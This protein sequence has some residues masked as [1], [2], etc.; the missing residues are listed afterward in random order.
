MLYSKYFIRISLF[1]V[2]VFACCC[3]Q[4]QL[5]TYPL[6]SGS[7]TPTNPGVGNAYPSSTG[8][9]SANVTTGVVS[10]G[11]NLEGA[12]A[13]SYNST[14]LRVKLGSGFN[15]WPGSPTDDYHVDVPIAP[16][17]NYD[18][19]ITGVSFVVSVAN[20]SEPLSVQILYRAGTGP[21]HNLGTAQSC[22]SVATV[23]F[24]TLNEGFYN[25]NNYTFRFYFFGAG[26]TKNQHIR[27]NNLVFNGTT[28]TPPSVKPTAHTDVASPF[29]T[30]AF[31]V[32]GHF[33]QGAGFHVANKAGFITSTNATPTFAN[34]TVTYAASPTSPLSENVNFLTPQTTYYT[35]AFVITS[36][37]T[38]LAPEI[39]PVTTFPYS[40]PLLNTTAPSNVLSNKATSG[41]NLIDSGGYGVVEK[42]VVY[43]ISNNLDYYTDPHTSNG[44]GNADYWSLM[45]SLQ[46]STKYYVMA[47]ARNQIGVGYGGLD[48]FTTLPAVPVISAIPGNLDFG[49]VV[50]STTAPIL[51]YKLSGA[52]LTGGSGVI[53]LTA[54]GGYKICATYNGSYGTTLSVPYSGTTLPNKIIYVQS[55]NT[56][57][58]N[59]SG[60]ITHSGGGA[61][62]PN[63]DTVFLK[64]AIVQNPDTLSN[65]GSDFWTGFGYQ[66]KMKDNTT[67]FDT[68]LSGKGSHLSL[69]VAAGSQ[70][71]SVIVELPGMTAPTFPRKVYVPANGFVEI[72][73]F[74]VGDGNAANPT[75]GP[76]TRLYYTGVSKRGIHIYSKNGT[77][78][79]CWMY[80]WNTGDAAAGAMLFPT[81]TWN[82]S[83]VVQSV[84]GKANNS[85]YNNNSFFFVIAKED[86]TVVTFKPT[87]DILDSN[88]Q[89]IFT[90][91]HLHNPTYVKYQKDSTYKVTLNKGEVFNAMG[92]VGDPAPASADPGALDLSG[93]VVST[94]CD[95]K[96][97]VFGGNGRCVIGTAGSSPTVGNANCNNPSSGSDNLIQQMF[98]KVAWGTTY[99]TVP[100][101]NMADNLFRVYVQ[102]INTD[103]KLN[104]V[105]LPKINLIKGLY[106]QFDL[107]SPAKVES[108]IPVSVTQFIVSGACQHAASGNIGKGDPEMITLSPVQ[109][110]IKST[111]VYSATFKNGNTPPS[112][113]CSYI[114]VVVKGSDGVSN[115]KLD[116]LTAGIDTGGN[117]FTGAIYAPAS[118]T[119]TNVNAF[120]KHPYDT[121]YYYAT[122]RVSSKAKHT[123]FSTQG[124][125]A[126]AYGV[127]DGES[128]GYN[129]G[130]TINNLSAIKFALNP[131]G[132]DTSTGSIKTCKNN[133]VTLQIALPYDT[134]TVNSIVWDAGS[135]GILYSPT[136]PNNSTLNPNTSKPAVTGIIVKDGRTFYIYRSPVQYQ[137]FEEG[138][139]KVKVTVNGTFVSDCG[140]VEYQNIS[141]I[142]G[143]DDISFTAVPAGCGSKS[144]TISDASTPLA[145][146]T[147]LKW[148]WD[149][150]DISTVD[151][152]RVGIGNAP[153][154]SVNPH[155]YPANNAYTI[156]LTTINSVGCFSV[157]SV[158]INL[159]FGI[160]TSFTIAKDT[161]CPGTAGAF[162]PTSST[163]AAKWFWDFGDGSPVDSSNATAA[164]V[165]HNYVQGDTFYVV[166]H[167][168]KTVAGCPSAIMKDTIY[169]TH[170]PIADFVLP[171]GVCLPGTTS[172]TNN[173]DT[174][175]GL[176]SNSMPYI[177]HWDFGVPSPVNDDT[178]NVKNPSYSYPNVTPPA[179]GYP[180]SLIATSKFG[181]V[182]TATIKNLNNIYPKPTAAISNT[183]DK[184]V[185]AGI[186]AKFFD[187]SPGGSGQTVNSWN[188]IFKNGTS[189]ATNP[190]NTYTTNILDTVKLFIGTDKGCQSD[191]ATWVI[192]VNPKP[193]AGTILPSSCLTSSSLNFKDNS[194]VAADDSVQ[195]P[196]TYTWTFGDGTGTFTTKDS[197]HTYATTGT[198]YI[199]HSITTLNGC[200]DTKTDTFELAG[201]KP[202]AYFTIPHRNLKYCDNEPVYLL[203]SSTISIGTI[204]KV[205]IRWDLN[206]NYSNVVTD[207]TPS[208]G[209]GGSTKQYS[210]NYPKQP[211]SQTYTVALYAYSSS[212]CYDS[213]TL[214]VDVF[215]APK[216]LFDTL[217]GVCVSSAPIRIDKALDSSGKFNSS[218]FANHYYT[219]NGVSSDSL[220]DP[221][222][223]GVG[224]HY[225]KALFTSK[226]PFPRY[227]R[228]SAIAPITV[229]ASPT[230]S[231]DTALI[232]CEK[233][234]MAF[235]DKSIAG[236]GTGNISKWLWKFGDP[237]KSP[238]DTSTSNPATYTY[239]NYGV[240]NVTLKVTSDSGC[241][242]TSTAV[243]VTVNPLPHVSFLYPAG[244]CSGT[245]V[246]FT[247]KS[248]IADGTE[249]SF[250]HYW[251]FGDPGSSALNTATG[252]PLVNPTHLYN[253]PPVDSVKLIVMSNNQCKDSMAV[254]LS[255]AVFPKQHATFTANGVRKDGDTARVCFN[256]GITFKNASP[257]AALSSYWVF[258]DSGWLVNNNTTP[259]HIYPTSG[260]FFGKHY[261]DDNNG[262]RSDTVDIFVRIW[263]LPTPIIVYQNPTCQGS[264]VL[265]KDSSIAG[266]GSGNIKITTT[267]NFGDPASGGLNTATGVTPQHVYSSASLTPYNVTIKVTTDSGCM[268]TS[269][270]PTPVTVHYLPQMKIGLPTSLCLPN[271]IATFTDS[272]TIAD[273]SESQFTHTWDFGHPSSGIFNT[274]TGKPLPSVSHTYDSSKNYTITLNILTKDGCTGSISKVLSAGVIHPQPHAA[275]GPRDSAKV[276]LNDAVVFNDASGSG[277][278]T[279]TWVWG[280]GFLENGTNPSPHVFASAGVYA[281]L[282][283]YDDNITGCRSDTADFVSIVYDRPSFSNIITKKILEGRSEILDPVITN[284]NTIKWTRIYP[285]GF[286]DDYLDVD[287]VEQPLC[288]PLVDSIV[289]K[290]HAVSGANCSKDTNYTVIRFYAP[291]IAN[292]FSPNG[293]GKNDFWDLSSLE[294][295]VG[296]SVQVFN[297]YGQVVL[298]QI[299]GKKWDGTHHI[300]HA[301]LPIGTYYYII[302]PGYG[303]EVMSGSVTILR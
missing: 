245:P 18:Y 266:A 65:A 177:Y 229:W 116:G 267:W 95:K 149:F 58:G 213:T 4:A 297:R 21:W 264:P 89:T 201:A 140:G 167:W 82:S 64:T 3:I 279:S 70:G 163:N 200:T 119:V 259:T 151:T 286:G 150:G 96:I 220:F 55:P 80:D 294:N 247:D 108:N 252:N 75:N 125:N 180:V 9:T 46:P 52:Y 185:C 156:K 13:G 10:V 214:T 192:K 216:V 148:A 268:A 257:I 193:V 22:N 113:G 158:N 101:K 235:T 132:N 93:T 102:D 74:P 282:H 261:M 53:N 295:F 217:R 98:P 272:S 105:L 226:I 63:A 118:A 219:G 176:S 274:A 23:N 40:V 97:A 188:W 287:N 38:I 189:T 237:V 8:L 27:M 121:G 292:A 289:Y 243:P 86:N 36:V 240:Y 207:N 173:S 137:F 265:F 48:S 281:G 221:A 239:A 134:T 155:I 190:T 111:T 244:T 25:G 145:G 255:T 45:T 147:I 12:T 112:Q 191:T 204:K 182:S 30:Y 117:T 24:G 211:F 141:I 168:V 129:A 31:N 146:T 233:N 14:G 284:A 143:H 215:P 66:E 109:Q 71:D 130:T 100:T 186:P 153:N 202:T 218:V 115:F 301:P 205:E 270:V 85:G 57:F 175:K 157:D 154:P 291:K 42:G 183:S 276:C 81:N 133:L 174:A 303:L 136:G 234:G 210:Y 195:T 15:I 275:V 62:P 179:G 283:Y 209:I 47:Y 78:V 41:G 278:G 170:K 251:N 225:I 178:S 135:N 254:K 232:K 34:S 73:G 17:P 228:D 120:R 293:D 87:N 296:S 300:S 69:F 290:I 166:Q 181:C 242:A 39:L 299:G 26:S 222:V 288:T 77:P 72:G 60:I 285:G 139:Y 33:D 260:L 59:L 230:A 99:L 91:G 142:V 238:S 6:K 67:Q 37:D 51:S 203:D 2:T 277:V 128:Y 104:N 250:T 206:N 165:T 123:L 172:F 159:A 84:G 162:T 68:T 127:S 298:T 223:A 187:A 44:I 29:S 198:Y 246:G 161:I 110:S 208:N 169:I 263:D 106:Y 76:D 194:T 79:S 196:Y 280:D 224:T 144:V 160:T 107:N 88:N 122:F 269:A 302:K 248:T 90:N 249:S 236:A 258:G 32:T 50:N 20:N 124:F 28:A 35:R 184:K 94:T 114:N 164:T 273:G 54:T 271:A 5:A 1:F 212:N 152:A 227:C 256:S 92:F 19:F 49:E 83:Y 56:P 16:K 199:N 131:Y 103:V 7:L 126:I 253:A 231:F 197:T 171:A 262:C 11:N 138:A 61:V 43:K 241:S